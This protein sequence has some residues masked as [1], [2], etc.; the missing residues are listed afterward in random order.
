VP[1]FERR[2][3]IRRSEEHAKRGAATGAA[4]RAP[5]RPYLVVR[6]DRKRARVP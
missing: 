4:G 3:V 6:E 5:D 1:A 2:P